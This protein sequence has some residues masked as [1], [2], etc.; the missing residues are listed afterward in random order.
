LVWLF[1]LF[2]TFL[3][4][5]ECRYER[6]DWSMCD[7]IF[8]LKNRTDV[9]KSNSKSLTHCADKRIVTKKCNEEG[10][11]KGKTKPYFY[12][13][14]LRF[15]LSL[16]KTEKLRC[17]VLSL[18]SLLVNARKKERTDWQLL[19]INTLQNRRSTKLHFTATNKLYVAW[20]FYKIDSRQLQTG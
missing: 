4:F 16:F 7:V 2:W 12:C 1:I 11:D 17:I 8:Q 10:K 15:G 18:K 19:Q 6:G 9:L 5:S 3:T 13:K 20:T 14:V